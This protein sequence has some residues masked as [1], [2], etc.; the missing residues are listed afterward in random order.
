[1]NTK[2]FYTASKTK[3]ANI[4]KKLRF[5]GH[6]VTATWIDEADAGET[7]DLAELAVRCIEDI[8]RASFL[9]IYSE[10][11]DVHKGGLME[12]GMALA[13]GKEIRCVGWCNSFGAVF[14]LH[15]L[16][17]RYDTVEKALER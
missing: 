4:W 13:L 14:H 5:E 10:P 12:V 11:G 3:H 9:L 2:P 16:W 7:D 6:P 15:P 1:M 17:K 8:K